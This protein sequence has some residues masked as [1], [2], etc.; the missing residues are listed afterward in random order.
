MF[1]KFLF[2]RL[3]FYWYTVFFLVPIVIVAGIAFSCVAF[4]PLPIQFPLSFSNF[5]LTI[6]L[7]FKQ[8]YTLFSDPLYLEGVLSSIKLAFQTMCICLFFGYIAAYSIS[9]IKKCYQGVALLFVCVP[10]FVP[11]LVRV[12]GW[13]GLLSYKGFVND[14]LL[15]LGFIKSP[16]IFL[17]TDGAVCLG[18][19][20]CYIPFMILPIYNALRGIDYH[21]IESSYDLGSSYF[22][23]FLKVTLPLSMH[24]VIAG[25]S[26]V[27]LTCLGEFVLPEFLGNS[28]TMTIGRIIWVE[29]FTHANWPLACAFAILFIF[30][31]VVV[32]VPFLSRRK[33]A[34]S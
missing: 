9:C 29:F 5:C 1:K 2:P 16:Y 10:L 26:F 13:M 19:V 3:L 23:T 14:V 17:A 32:T 4:K 31:V 30:C 25:S 21:Y 28:S 6:T 24:G 12:Y 15:Y 22:W 33:S 7:N 34:A 11:F 20:Y 27:F 8:F 18:M